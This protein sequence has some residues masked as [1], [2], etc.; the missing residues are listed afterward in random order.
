M[1]PADAQPERKFAHSELEDAYDSAMR[2]IRRVDQMEY[3]LKRVKAEVSDTEI[4]FD[5]DQNLYYVSWGEKAT[6]YFDGDWSG[7]LCCNEGDTK[8]PDV[9]DEGFLKRLNAL[10]TGDYGDDDD[11]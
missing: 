8:I 10:A 11:E 3:V 1:N 9:R 6:L 5:L 7:E 4:E 2:T